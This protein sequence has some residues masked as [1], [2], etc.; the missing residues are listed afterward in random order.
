MVDISKLQPAWHDH[1]TDVPKWITIGIGQVAME[2]ATVERELEELIRLLLDGDVQLVRILT[3]E[4]NAKRRVLI[5]TNLIQAHI[6]NERLAR[7]HLRRVN[8]IKKKIEDL[9][10]KRDVLAHGLWA[11]YPEYGWGVLR[12]RQSRSTPQ[13][14]PTLDSLHRAVLPQREFVTSEK[15]FNWTRAI[16]ALA[17]EIVRL[18]DHLAKE[19]AP[20][21]IARPQY[22]RRRP[23]YRQAKRRVSSTDDPRTALAE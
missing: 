20:L 5:A 8:R 16:V 15:I 22:T 21:R 11:E 10:I 9:E 14:H 4:M 2:W 17:K 7:R 19:L 12:M 1:T 13:L 3:N 6:I 18:C 23:A